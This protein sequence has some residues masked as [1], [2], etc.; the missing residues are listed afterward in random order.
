L[1]CG[2]SCEI[3]DQ[4]AA[5]DMLQRF[6]ERLT[7]TTILKHIQADPDMCLLRDHP[8]FVEM[9]AAAKSRLGVID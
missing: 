6:F 9:L 4:H 2:L 7:S 1:A 3:K 5:L 8:R